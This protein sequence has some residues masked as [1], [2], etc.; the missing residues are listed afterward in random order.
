MSRKKDFALLAAGILVGVALAPTAAN[1]VSELLTATPSTQTFYLDDQ[2]IELEAYAINGHNYV[3]LRDVGYSPRYRS[4]HRAK[5]RGQH[6]PHTDR[7]PH[8]EQP[9][10]GP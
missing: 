9:S 2:Q 7:T 1:A 10:Q 6:H 5:I 4:L 8:Y 3:K